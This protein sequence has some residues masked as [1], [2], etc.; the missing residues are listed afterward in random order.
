MAVI[1]TPSANADTLTGDSAADSI[2][3]MGGND[4][5]PALPRPGQGVG[6]AAGR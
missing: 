6:P 3:G 5:P 1:G 2:N 4:R